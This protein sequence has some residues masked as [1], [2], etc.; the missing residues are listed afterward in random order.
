MA[1]ITALSWAVL[2][3]ALKLALKSFSSETIV[4][5]RMAAAATMMVA[6]FSWRRRPWLKIL[7]NP[8]WQGLLCGA[9]ITV[10]YFGFMKGVE[11]TTASNAQILIQLA[12]LSFALM[13]IFIYK[14]TPTWMQGLG[15]AIAL[16]GF[17]FFYWDQILVSADRLAEFQ[18]GNLWLLAAAGSWAI[19]ALIQKSLLKRFPPQQINLLIYTC[20]A[21]LLVPTANLSELHHVSWG[22]GWLLFFLAANT[23]VGYGA[24]AEAISRIPASQVSMIIA[25][26]PLLTIFIMTTL[27][28]MEVEWLKAEPIHWRGFVGALLVVAGV[29]LTVRKP[30]RLSR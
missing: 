13:S 18:T 15:M 27:A 21:I 11:L 19:F 20:S 30:V 25:V 29:I 6:L 8:P 28:Q 1:V 16:S 5:V 24:L 10:N 4:W 22:Q 23:V 17:G 7:S 3:I 2:A 9:M 12:P 26:N 14:E